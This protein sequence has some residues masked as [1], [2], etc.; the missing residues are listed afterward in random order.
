MW[1]KYTNWELAA[2]VPL[3]IAAPHK[4]ASHGVVSLALMELVDVRL[5]A[6]NPY[7]PCPPPPDT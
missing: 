4:P 7:P 5:H 2:R 1:E 6:P 3:I